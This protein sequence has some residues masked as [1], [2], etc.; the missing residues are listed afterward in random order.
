MKNKLRRFNAFRRGWTD[1]ASI[2]QSAEIDKDYVLGYERGEQARR[3][4][5]DVARARLGIAPMELAK[6]LGRSE[7]ED[8]D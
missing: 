8:V 7:A 1:G 2:R 4:Y 3:E 5:F 6:L